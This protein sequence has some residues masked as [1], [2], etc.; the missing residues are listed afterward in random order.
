MRFAIKL[1]LAF[2]AAGALVAAAPAMFV[3]A[4]SAASAAPVQHAQTAHVVIRN[5]HL[6]IAI[7]L[8]PGRNAVS[9][10]VGLNS[11]SDSGLAAAS[12]APEVQVRVGPHNCAGYNGEVED[13]W[14]PIYDWPIIETWGTAWDDCYGY[15]NWPSTTY[16]YVSYS[17]LDEPRQNFEAGSV[18]DGGSAGASTGIA[19]GPILTADIFL[20]SDIV[21]TA[22][23]QSI[24]GW[25][26]GAGQK[27]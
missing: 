10:A 25:A 4:A 2:M 22:C 19:T 9:E 26:C 11:R 12:T 20:P 23:I 1:A 3:G 5:G 21:V 14:V 6:A 17:E 27:V 13:V 8:R 16:V 18:H 15:Y 24:D 7:P